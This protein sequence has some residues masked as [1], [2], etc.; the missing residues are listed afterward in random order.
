MDDLVLKSIDNRMRDEKSFYLPKKDYTYIRD[1]YGEDYII[2]FV[3]EA[4]K[5]YNIEYPIETRTDN[6]IYEAFLKLQKELPY[7]YIILNNKFF[8]K[9]EYDCITEEKKLFYIKINSSFNIVSKYFNLLNRNKTATNRGI[10]IYDKYHDEKQFRRILRGIITLGYDSIDYKRLSSS[11]ACRGSAGTPIQF[12]VNTARCIYHLFNAKNVLDFSAGWGDRLA[13]FCSLK[14]TQS[15]VGI[16][17]FKAVYDN[18]YKQVELYK[19]DKKFTFINQPAEDVDYSQYNFDFIFTSPPY[20]NV[21]LYDA[22]SETNSHK[23][24]SNLEFMV[25][26]F[27]V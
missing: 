7:K 20:F 10:S 8:H 11:F 15:Y 18:Y 23:R 22:D 21:E 16:D 25:K 5:K 9:F 1:M 3:I 12:N 13:G 14:D 27:S 17:P 2:D 19:V 24:Y 26:W 6:E 4:I